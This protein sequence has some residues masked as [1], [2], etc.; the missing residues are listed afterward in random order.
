[1]VIKR[2]LAFNPK[3]FLAQVGE[4]RS[5]G[6]YHN[7]E[8]VFSQG[9]PAETV[10]YIEKGKVKITV[11]SEQGKEA[12]VAILGANDFFG[13]ECLARQARRK[14]TVATMTDAVIVRLEKAAMAR[15]VHQETAFS[16]MFIEHL[17]DR[18][19]RGSKFEPGIPLE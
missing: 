10:F 16:E 6:K 18:T 7:N 19:I 17:L 12:V 2:K 15:V 14:A 1:M 4:G 5:I 8:V 11:V 13:E 3:S 9:D